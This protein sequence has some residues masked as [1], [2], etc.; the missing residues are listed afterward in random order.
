MPTLDRQDA[1]FAST[2]ATRAY[3]PGSTLTKENDGDPP[4]TSPL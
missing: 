2:S 3:T 1:P 4:P